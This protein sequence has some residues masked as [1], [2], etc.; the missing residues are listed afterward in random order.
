M[1]SKA[2]VNSAVSSRDLT[3]GEAVCK[4]PSASFSSRRT[5]ARIGPEM[6]LPT[7]T[8]TG[9]VASTTRNTTRIVSRMLRSRVDLNSL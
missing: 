2:F 8:A 1:V 3:T 6:D 5:Q 4:S 9:K 7:N